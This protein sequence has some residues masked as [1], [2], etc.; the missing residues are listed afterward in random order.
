MAVPQYALSFPGNF[1]RIRKHQP[2]IPVVIARPQAVAISR[3]AVG[4]RTMS[5]RFPRGFA[6]LVQ[7]LG[8]KFGKLND[9]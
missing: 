6:E 5:R 7:Y 2:L 8:Q 3:Q 4:I 9:S 1:G